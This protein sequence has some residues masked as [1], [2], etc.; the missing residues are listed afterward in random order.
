MLWKQLVML[1]LSLRIKQRFKLQF[2]RKVRKLYVFSTKF[3]KVDSEEL[4]HLTLHEL[5][6]TIEKGKFGAHDIGG[7]IGCFLAI[8]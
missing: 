3:F 8:N 4:S 5:L 2:K 1:R 7:G 6:E